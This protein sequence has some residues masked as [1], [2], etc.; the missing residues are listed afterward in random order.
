VL[1]PLPRRSLSYAA[2]LTARTNTTKLPDG[3]RCP[4]FALA[5]RCH[6][7]P[8]PDLDSR[9]N[10]GEEK[11]RDPAGTAGR[12]VREALLVI[13]GTTEAQDWSINMEEAPVPFAYIPT[14]TTPPPRTDAATGADTDATTD[15]TTA[16]TGAGGEV[17]G[18]VHAGMHKGATGILDCYG[19]RTALLTLAAKVMS[20]HTSP[21]PLP[22][23]SH[24]HPHTA[25]PHP[26]FTLARWTG[27]QTD[28]RGS[29]LGRRHRRV[30]RRRVAQFARRHPRR[31]QRR[32]RRR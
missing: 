27:V 13:R 19:L 11:R 3:R 8:T 7:P 2:Q 20:I 24:P 32:Q 5:L 22:P 12:V 15:A 26:S 10:S 29:L 1:P 14:R 16:A 21:T 17:H 9:S 4:A 30:G 31:R 28:H 23:T 6:R 18:H 25:S